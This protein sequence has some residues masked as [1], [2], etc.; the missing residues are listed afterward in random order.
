MKNLFLIAGFTTALAITVCGQVKPTQDSGWIMLF[1]GSS[2]DGWRAYNGEHM[3]PG[4][5]IVAGELT[6][7]QQLAQQQDP[8]YKGSHDLIY[9]AQEFEKFELYLEWKIPPGGNSGIFYHVVE[10]HE[11]ISDIAPEYQLIDDVNYTKFHDITRY[12]KSLGITDNPQDLQP[13]QSTGADYGMYAPD[14][15]SKVLHPAGEWNSTRIVFT[16][17]RV[18]HWL[19]GKLLL[20]FAPWSEDWQARKK[21]SKWATS[22]KYGS[23]KKGFIGIQD[24]GSPL[25]F[26]NIKVKPL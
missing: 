2:L 25:W 8:E 15:S 17:Q 23:S 26:R 5:N 22:P 13:L 7:S 24:H 14:E 20:S 12:N 4:W 6:F 11:R 9:G 21:K 19:N 18:E 3:P 1:D 10:G 16:P